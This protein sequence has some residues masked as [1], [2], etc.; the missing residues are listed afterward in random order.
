[1]TDL[2]VIALRALS[3]VTSL[4]AAGIPL[5]LWLF[6]DGLPHATRPVTTLARRTALAALVLVISYQLIEPARLTGEL[7]GI[8]DGSLQTALLRSELGT[9]SA[10]RAL[11]LVCVIVG[12]VRSTRLGAAVSLAGGTLIAASFAFMGHTAADEQRWLL[13]SLLLMHVWVVAFW[14]GALWPLHL[15]SRH[16]GL[17]ANAAIVARFSKIAVSLV[18]LIFVAGLALA[19]VLLPDLASLRT[20]YGALLTVKVAGF[21]LLMGLA[22]LNK[23]RLGPAIGAGDA[24]A[25][26][27]LRR[28]VLLEWLLL[29]AVVTAT[30]TMT[31]LF[32]PES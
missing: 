6:G 5:F 26:V 12:L 25:L 1:M 17:A 7:R 3:F 30:A 11:G 15:A 10:V 20:A 16:E 27:Y 28:S 22:A 31:G 14:F 21:A 9:T 29:A 23:W 8:F 19:V 32:S 4:Q 18:P 13:A 24:G 2:T